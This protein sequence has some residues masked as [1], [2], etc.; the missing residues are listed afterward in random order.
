L[1]RSFIACCTGLWQRAGATILIIGRSIMEN[2]E[3]RSDRD[4]IK[5]V[6]IMTVVSYTAFLQTALDTLTLSE[7]ETL[8]LDGFKDF[9]E[10]DD[11]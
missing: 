2:E 9:G 6:I 4:I 7:A 3:F 10:K 8:W 5:D 1:G 11:S